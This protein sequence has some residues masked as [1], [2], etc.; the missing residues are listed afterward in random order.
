[1]CGIFGY[2]GA[3]NAIKIVLSGLKKLEYRGYDSAGVAGIKDGK[4]LFCKEVGKVAV[5]EE[6]VN[7]EGIVCDIGIA[8]SRWATHG[9]P[10]ITNAHPH[11]DT[12][13]SLAL[14]HNGI[15]EN[16]EELRNSLKEKGVQ[17][18]SDTDTEVV[19]HLIASFYN[20]DILKAVQQATPMLEGSYAIAL[21]HRN[22]PNQIIAMANQSPLIIGVGNNE[23][24]ISSDSHAF[25]S[26]TREVIYLADGEIAVVTPDQVEIFDS[27][28]T[29]LTRAPSTLGAAP[30]EHSKGDF[31]HFTLKEIFQQP[32]TIRNALLSRFL[33][34]YGTVIFDE[35]NFNINELQAVERVLILACGTSLHAG[36]IGSYMLEEKARLPV[37]VEISS[38][39]RYKNPVIPPGTFVIAISQSGETADTI[40]AVKEA[41]E[42]GAK[43]LA[44]C[45]VQGSTLVRESDASIFLRAGPEVGVCSTKAF[46]SQ[47]VVLALLTLMLARMR[48]MSKPEGQAFLHALQKLPDQVQEVLNHA[49]HIEAIA[50]KY[51]SYEDAFFV[52][53]HFMYPTSLEGALKL[54]EISYINAN[55]YPAGEMKHGPI[56]LINA[57]SLVVALCCNQLTFTKLLSNLMELKAR[58]API[59][60]IAEEGDE[61]KLDGIA[62]D[63]ILISPTIDELASIPA[64]V[65]A[66][67][68][69]Y[70]VARERGA[71]IDQ[72]RNLAK[73]VT[74]E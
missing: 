36:Y 6:K 39:F 69:A 26:H 28:M 18:I 65:A 7:A 5:L 49:A 27:A 4:I 64:S 71:D 40:A 1:M 46:T 44:I 19:A 52:G 58:G 12:A 73:S 34:D 24:F 15:I 21:I 60:A 22:H 54:K 50:K 42:K 14:V 35:V 66:Q 17:F 53:R 41:K 33:E 63:I 9:K 37:R 62:D 2:V 68:F 29:K 13:H 16:Y 59:L 47:V 38:E 48:H 3:Q 67:L 10:T 51:A 20:G 30:E 43:I 23:I 74:V 72:P 25:A 11:F 31:E 56:A 45:N 55:G 61:D 8:H 57:Q 70:Y 32:Q